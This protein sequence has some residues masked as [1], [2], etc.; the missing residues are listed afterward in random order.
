MIY[1]INLKSL[2]IILL[3]FLKVNGAMNKFI[4]NFYNN[5]KRPRNNYKYLIENL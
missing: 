1:F 5:I 3:E 2:L 4:N